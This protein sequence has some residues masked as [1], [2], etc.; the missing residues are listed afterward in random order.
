MN[1]GRIFVGLV[2]LATMGTMM[3]GAL[4]AD[5][6]FAGEDVN[7]LTQ[8]AGMTGGLFRSDNYEYTQPVLYRYDGD[9][10]V[11]QGRHY[12]WTLVKSFGGIRQFLYHTDRAIDY[13][14]A[15][16]IDRNSGKVWGERALPV[17]IR[18][19]LNKTATLHEKKVKE[20]QLEW[21][22][23]LFNARLRLVTAYE[24]L[25]AWGLDADTVVGSAVAAYRAYVGD[26][27]WKRLNDRDP[28]KRNLAFK[29]LTRLDA[30]LNEAIDVLYDPLLAKK[31]AAFREW[32]VAHPELA[33][34]LAEKRRT[35][36]LEAQIRDAES[37]AAQAQFAAR[38]AQDEAAAAWSAASDAEARA[39][40]AERK[41]RDAESRA[42]DA[43]SRW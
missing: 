34:T 13:G 20:I 32:E 8:R 29:A 42:M 15:K 12:D 39:E 18:G 40:A 14:T 24:E 21:R 1:R 17:E 30:N 38:M 11:Y 23:Y 43:E 22:K 10:V 5:Y 26:K 25:Q 2:V 35:A 9:Y 33:R 4:A 41:A 37:R 19:L 7:Y 6:T 16:R 36:E 28:K 3:F 31:E 27:A